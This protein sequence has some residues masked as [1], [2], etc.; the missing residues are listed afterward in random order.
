VSGSGMQLPPPMPPGRADHGGLP[1]NPTNVPGS[2]ASQPASHGNQ[3]GSPPANQSARPSASLPSRPAA[4]LP[5]ATRRSGASSRT[6]IDADVARHA[7][8]PLPPLRSVVFVCHGP[9]CTERGSPDLCRQLR[10][11]LNES[12]ARRAVRV[13]ETTCLDHCATGPNMLISQEGAIQT[14]L[15]AERLDDLVALLTGG[16]EKPK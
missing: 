12:S 5:P 13:C 11:K 3:P 8:I 7:G 14:G 15:A 1:G 2:Q 4:N 9:S 6:R 10:A 16:G